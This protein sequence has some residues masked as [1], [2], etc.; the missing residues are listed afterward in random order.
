[1]LLSYIFSFIIRPIELIFEFIFSSAYK[2]TGNPGVSVIFVGIIMNILILPIYV[3]ADKISKDQADKEKKM[4][5]FIA[6][7]NKAFKGDERFMMLQAFY[8]QKEYNPLS[9]LLSSLSLLLEIPFFIAGFH[10]LSG[11]NIV[12]GIPFLFVKDLS[13]PD[14]L[15]SLGGLTVNILPILMTV[16]N[17][18]SSAIYSKNQTKRAK[19]Q[20]YL[21][22]LVFL[23]LLYNS[24]ACLVIYW[25]TNNLFSL[26]KN[27]IMET[28]IGD[29]IRKTRISLPNIPIFEGKANRED[30]A[31][32][33][34][35]LIF[36]GS[37]TGFLV[38]SD[39]VATAV[40]SFMSPVDLVNPMIFIV[41]AT[42]IAWGMYVLWGGII[43]YMLPDRGKKILGFLGVCISLI[44]ILDYFGFGAL[45]TLTPTLQFQFGYLDPGFN[46][47]F[48]N[49]LVIVLI[50]MLIFILYKNIKNILI[51]VLTVG[52]LSVFVL[53][54]INAYKITSEYKDCLYIR[55][56]NEP[57]VFELSREGNNVI[58]LMLDRMA[59]YMVPYVFNE[60]P[61]LYD[62][63]D[64]FTFYPNTISFGNYTLTGSPG[65]F[66]GYDYIP[67][68]MNADSNTELR[69]KQNNAL[70]VMPLN[71]LDEGYNVTVADPVYADYKWFPDLSIYADHPEINTYITNGNY[72]YFADGNVFRKVWERNLF[73]FSFFRLSPVVFRELLYDDG[74]YNA[75][76]R[77]HFNDFIQIAGDP[78][79]ARGYNPDFM[80]A[81]TV[82]T[83]LDE[84]TQFTDSG[85]SFV[86]FVNNTVHDSA[87]L[88]E[89]EY[90]PALYIDNTEFDVQ[91]A[92]RMIL[93]GNDLN[94][95]NVLQYGY[96]E[97]C[98][99]AFQKI[100]DWLDYLRANDCYDNTR[101]IIV[102][103]HGFNVH[104]DDPVL[105]D[106]ADAEHFNPVLLVK[107]F[108]SEGF[109]VS[110]EFMTNADTPLLAME[111]IVDSP[112]NPATGIPLSDDPKYDRP[113][114]I[115]DYPNF[116]LF[117]NHGATTYTEGMW[118]DVYSDVFD[119]EG[120]VYAGI[121]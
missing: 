55:D 13:L 38:T 43:Y 63:Y 90:E 51:S 47:I 100:G 72:N 10:L 36:M 26:F 39:I 18:I 41:N 88:S 20:T 31:I 34:M 48:M 121:H 70:R 69:I 112:V 75:A 21:L 117:D 110:E 102:A 77:D 85:D 97:S 30:H 106:G 96:Y 1:M 19:I 103:D 25:T 65:L 35:S 76:D 9:I 33:I 14:S 95:H 50:L 5:P 15:F 66:G 6:M 79:T 59:G 93:N 115:F 109:T 45:G 84:I 27:I 40:E 42:F 94:I 49:C 92:D 62:T 4:K 8:R 82:L 114:H 99:C 57:A 7:I 32:A 29:K 116:L 98:V 81:Y 3:K 17:L 61:S 12:K 118:Y 101:I 44:C 37:L 28:F 86:M 58:V 83:S 107:D 120:W 71:F 111:G 22:A 104:Q 113:L 24:P 2:L 46:K 119:E 52:L 54:G 23:V 89:P 108:G 16:I 56:E 73:C 68:R 60:D 11:L 53:G 67:E 64:G 91:H 87:I 80:D 105:F 74:M 78:H